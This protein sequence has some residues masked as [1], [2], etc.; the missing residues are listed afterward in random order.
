MPEQISG[1]F[2][3]CCHVMEATCKIFRVIRY[4]YGAIIDELI[5]CQYL[6]FMILYNKYLHIGGSTIEEPW[7]RQKT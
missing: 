2:I 7:N 6:Q 5:G 3:I 4:K 1:F